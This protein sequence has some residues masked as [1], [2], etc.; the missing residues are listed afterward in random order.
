MSDVLDGSMTPEA[1]KA[2]V[3]ALK[4]IHPDYSSVSDVLTV[5]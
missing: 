5:E 4:N 1:G 3:E 2:K